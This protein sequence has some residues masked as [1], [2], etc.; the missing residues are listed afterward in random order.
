M[1]ATRILEREGYRVLGAADGRQGEDLFAGNM[2]EIDVVLSDLVLPGLGG[3]ELAERF[4][5][6]RPA[7]PV[8]LMSGYTDRDVGSI[9]DEGAKTSFLKKPFTP[10]ALVQCVA[11]MIGSREEPSRARLAAG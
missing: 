5:E 2:N 10:D 7:L 6:R 11:A 9:T 3:I 8:I 4:R 1:L